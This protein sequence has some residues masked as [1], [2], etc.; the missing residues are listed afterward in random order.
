M[1]RQSFYI[2]FQ[3][4]QHCTS[5]ARAPLCTAITLN[6]NTRTQRTQ[7]MTII[8]MYVGRHRWAHGGQLGRDAHGAQIPR[9][10][11]LVVSQVL[12]HAF[13]SI[14]LI[15]LPNTA[16]RYLGKTVNERSPDFTSVMPTLN[17]FIPSPQRAMLSV[18]LSIFFPC[19]ALPLWSPS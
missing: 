18:K 11:N 6:M 2:V 13:W 10:V 8:Y 14:I 15:I 19:F 4:I 16:E 1:L 5:V 9:L 12:M 17:S 7:G 3:D